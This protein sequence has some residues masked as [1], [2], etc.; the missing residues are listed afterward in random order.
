MVLNHGK[1]KECL[2]GPEV[3]ARGPNFIHRKKWLPPL[4]RLAWHGYCALRQSLFADQPP[5]TSHLMPDIFNHTVQTLIYTTEAIGVAVI[6][7]GFVYATVVFLSQAMRR[8]TRGSY[9]DFRRHSVRG[10]ILG[11]EFLVAADI[12]KTVAI[13][14]TVESVLMLAVIIGLRTF[15]VFA[16]HLEVE[17]RL[18]WSQQD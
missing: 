7:G 5:V 13:E 15:L 6:M 14:Y 9:G 18:P 10:L 8:S 4:R 16:L 12:I 1:E 17:G 3:K 11:L 2:S